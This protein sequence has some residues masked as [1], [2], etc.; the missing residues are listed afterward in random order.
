MTSTRLDQ[1]PISEHDDVSPRDGCE[2][3]ILMPCLDEAETIETCI[4][5]ATSF[6]SEYGID[7]EVLIADNGSTDG[8]IDI[9]SAC[10]A[11]VV[12]VPQRGY[13]SALLG[14]IEAA[15]GKYIIMGDADD[16]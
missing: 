15:Q 2:L 7:G 9:A 8:S 12:H 13:G 4:R 6:L 16:S 1:A 14:G 10:G 11:R 3:T 5:K